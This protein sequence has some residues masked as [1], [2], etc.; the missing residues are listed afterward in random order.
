[1]LNSYAAWVVE[2]N[3]I[4]S[5]ATW[6]YSSSLWVYCMCTHLLT[7]KHNFHLSLSL[8]NE[9]LARKKKKKRIQEFLPGNKMCQMN[10]EGEARMKKEV[11]NLCGTSQALCLISDQRFMSALLIFRLFAHPCYFSQVSLHT[12]N[13]TRK[14]VFVPAESSVILILPIF[15]H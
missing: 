8:H 15:L 5:N 14:S 11:A 9:N 7:T 2:I 13:S 12:F 4:A 3:M 10:G 1:M 6:L